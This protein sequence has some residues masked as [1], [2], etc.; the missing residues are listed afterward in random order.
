MKPIRFS[1]HARQSMNA[2][3]AGEDE[4]IEAFRLGA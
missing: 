4:V 1:A 3:G 2:R